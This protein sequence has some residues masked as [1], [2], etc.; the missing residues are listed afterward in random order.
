MHHGAQLCLGWTCR[1]KKQ[2][3]Q[4]KNHHYPRGKK[5]HKAFLA[6]GKENRGE[7]LPPAQS[8]PSEPSRAQ[9]QGLAVSDQAQIRVRQDH[10]LFIHTVL[11]F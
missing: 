1:F 5:T 3:R 10:D 11:K 9:E 2:L 6:Q 8:S 4:D 7:M